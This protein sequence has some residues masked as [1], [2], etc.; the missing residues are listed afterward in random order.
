M[1]PLLAWSKINSSSWR[2][3]IGS[4][5]TPRLRRYVYCFAHILSGTGCPA[6]IPQRRLQLLILPTAT[7]CTRPW[8]LVLAVDAN[9]LVYAADADSQFHRPCRDWRER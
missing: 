8:A 2:E 5:G 3:V 6:D 9:V 4:G 7:P 1:G